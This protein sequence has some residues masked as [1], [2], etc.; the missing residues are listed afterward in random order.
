M[1][2][3]GLLAAL[4]RAFTEAEIDW[5]ACT[6]EGRGD[7]ALIFVPARYPENQ[8]A[9]RLPPRL[10]AG[11]R[12]H[13][14]TSAEG[15]RMRVR[16]ALH[17]G[18]VDVVPNGSTN[19]PV[20]FAC[21]LVDSEEAR[22]AQRASEDLITIIVSDSFYLD[23]VQHEPAAEPET[24][25]R[26]R[27]DVKEVHA[28][29]WIRSTAPTPEIEIGVHALT[30]ALVNIESL[31]Q[32]SPRSE[33]LDRLPDWMS[34]ALPRDAGLWP[35]AHAL[36]D[37]CATDP[38]ALEHLIEAI[39]RQE[40]DSASV[41]Q[42]MAMRSNS[43]GNELLGI[44]AEAETPDL[45]DVYRKVA[46]P[47]TIPPGAEPGL[48]E[49]LESLEALNARPDG[50][51][52]TLV[53]AEY[54][55]ARLRPAFK[56]R[57]RQWA[58]ARAAEMN[59]GSELEEVRKEA[60]GYSAPASTGKPVAYLVLQ[61][62]REGPS[63][64]R[65]RLS[66]WRQLGEPSQWAPSRSED[67]VGSLEATKATVASLIDEIER[68]WGPSQPDIRIE[69]VLDTPDLGLAVEQWPWE[70]DPQSEPIG[71]RYPA[72]LRSAERMRTHRYHR[73]W[74]R[75]WDELTRQLDRDQRIAPHHVVRGGGDDEA[76]RRR[77]MGALSLER[78][79]VSVVLSAPPQPE[80]AGQDEISISLKAGVPL[81]LWHRDD[82]GSPEFAG[83][84]KKLLHAG[85]D[86][87][88]HL[89]ERVRQTR[90]MAFATEPHETH[91]G[92]ALMVL[93]D[94]PTRLVLPHQPSPPL[95]VE[96]AK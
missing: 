60:R 93:Y 72:V 36:A 90:V 68:D 54:V 19:T 53:F 7:G 15:G 28:Y 3:T 51:P 17:S 80:L 42:L 65:I 8:L 58:A 41:V 11:L 24:Y 73:D 18:P 84:I 34:S 6:V 75:R 46:S 87:P 21:R 78:D 56:I 39:R 13:N 43:A 26:V 62:Q 64:D 37:L 32:R 16:L 52:R 50:L 44:L 82:C 71:C 70:T 10:A 59:L 45:A 83:G 49:I 96:A 57:V 88:D 47:A 9:D 85:D 67:K 38:H 30:N 95:E 55:A 4:E 63:G 22:E 29:A 1:M 35:L 12:R 74:R 86:N 48:A 91:I 81:I 33:V 40:G 89:L 92:S 23:T 5:S 76:G 77:L 2:Q 20:I 66:D 61:I 94:D 27:I 25:R 79:A 69:F 14:V 31:Q